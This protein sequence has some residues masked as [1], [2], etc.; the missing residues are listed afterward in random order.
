[1]TTPSAPV[2][3]GPVR[4][5]NHLPIALIAGPCQMESRAHALETAAALKEIAARRGIGLIYK[6]SY[7]KANRT[8][9]KAARGLGMEAALPVFAE[10]RESLGL[11][12]LTDVH[13]AAHCAPVA[14][15]VDVLQIPAFLCRQTDLLVAAARTGRAVNVKKGQF[16]APWDMAHVAAKV[17]ESGNPRVFLTER[18][19]SFGYNTLVSDMRALPIMARTGHPVVFDATHSV[20]QPGGQGASSGGQREFVETLARA[21]VAVGVAGLFI[22]THQDPD[23]APSDGPNMVP[24]SQFEALVAR[25]QAIDALVKG[26]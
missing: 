19:A 23:R 1:M 26:F 9:G 4:L 3:I 12:T 20:Q 24:L 13:E 21:A 11:P 15:A 14:E 8:S 6:T 25:L 5:A 22:E 7:D 17:T 2:E 16:L 10:I 18:G